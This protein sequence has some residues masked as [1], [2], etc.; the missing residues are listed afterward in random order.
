MNRD[1]DDEEEE[2]ELDEEDDRYRALRPTKETEAMTDE[3]LEATVADLTFKMNSFDLRAY[4]TKEEYEG[5]NQADRVAVEQAVAVMRTRMAAAIAREKNGD[6]AGASPEPEIKLISSADLEEP[7]REMPESLRE[8]RRCEYIKA[9]N[10]QCSA[11]AKVRGRLCYFHDQARP[12]KKA[13]NLMQLPVLED[14]RAVQLAITRV[15]QRISDDNI[16]VKRAS[17]LLYGLQ[18]ASSA[19]GKPPNR[20]K[21]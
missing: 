11:P 15:C 8:A 18:V 4:L 9:N 21:R 20:R 17:A 14:Q 13:K 7:S 12:G 3:E 5:I 2:D 16:D 19:I 10:Q 6:S 1:W